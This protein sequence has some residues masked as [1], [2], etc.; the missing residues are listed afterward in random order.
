MTPEQAKHIRAETQRLVQILRSSGQ[1]FSSF[2]TEDVLQP[3]K[4]GTFVHTEAI[5]RYWQNPNNGR[6]EIHGVTRD[7]SDRKRAEEA[8]RESEQKYRFLTETMKDV[9]W[10]LNRN[11]PLHLR[12]P[13]VIN[14]R[15]YTPE[16]IWLPPSRIQ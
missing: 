15:G 9:V 11:L 14:P 16:E 2:V 8:L 7:I 5:V 12:Q 4:D 1:P 10:I 13:A 6:V 3:R